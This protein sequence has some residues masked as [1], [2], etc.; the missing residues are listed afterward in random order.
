M[1][2]A[3]KTIVSRHHGEFPIELSAVQSLP[4]IGRYTAGAI[5]S[6]AHDARHPILEANTARLYSRLLAFQGDISRADGQRQLW[7]FAESILPR[8]SVGKFNQALM[9]LGATICTPRNPDC[10]HCP[11]ATMCPT[12]ARGLQ[13]SIPAAPRRT[14]YENV[15]E[16]C[17][18]V[19]KR[20][21]VLLR[22]CRDGERWSGM[23]DFPRFSL[24]EPQ[25]DVNRQITENV[26]RLTGLAIEPQ[27][28][29]T[30]LKHGVTRFRITL[31]CFQASWCQGRVRDRLQ[32]WVMPRDIH[33][34]PLSTTA[35]K[36]AQMLG[37]DL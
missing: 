16:A 6:I 13:S 10:E 1:H 21:R 24:P 26:L 33:A 7:E 31:E 9:E 29:L 14:I 2:L 5:L 32:R 3:A 23:W 28:R 25:R 19:W 4:G 35:R 11:V 27:Q 8:T 17:V 37:D 18:V 30:T 34:F 20:N 22:R 12:R 36:I 15:H